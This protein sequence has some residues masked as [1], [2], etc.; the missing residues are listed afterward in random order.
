M[1][2]KGF[3]LAGL[4]VFLAG[5]TLIPKYDQP[6]APV[7][8]TWP[9]GPAY[10]ET[11]AGVPAAAELGWREFFDDRRLKKVIETALANNRDL[12]VATLNVERARALYRIRRNELF[13][14]V[15]AAGSGGKER[16]PGGLSPFG[17]SYTSEYYSVSLG[18]AAWE[19]DFFGRI[20]SLKQKALEEYFASEEARRGARILLIS[21]VAGAYLT[22]AADREALQLARATLTAQQEAYDLIRRRYEKGLATA[23]DLKQ[24]QTQVDAARVDI[25]RYMQLAALDENALN[26]LAGFPVTGDLL[27]E[28]LTAVIPPREIA[29]GMPS[30]VLLKRPDILAA[31][32]LL[33]AAHA[34]IGAAR[35]ALFPRITLTTAIGTA[36]DQ[37]SGLFKAGSDTW[38]F[39]SQIVLPVF[40]ARAWGALEATKVE[41]EI[42]V[43]QYERA[44]QT[45]FREVADALAQRGTAGDQLEAQESLVEATAE[46]YR[47]ANLRYTKGVDSYLGVLDAQ[48]ALYA[49]Q[50]GLIKIRLANLASQVRLYAVLGGGRE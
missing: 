6:Q 44:I 18:V 49:T 4:C 9:G 10:K 12:R 30:E 14:A 41:R 28:S 23:L 27:P 31:E 7:P 25:A 48:R 21:E 33:K 43:A 45:A 50:A 15:N 22:L 24:A 8:A 42:A 35:A 5:C 34:N 40:D 47:L 37:L 16:V 19:I 13:P 46:T 11:G 17:Q 20:R 1:K 26:L 3:L 36:S 32:N 2:G 29:A 38:N 39:S